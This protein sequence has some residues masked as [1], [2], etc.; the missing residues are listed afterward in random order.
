MI[1][2]LLTRL[3]FALLTLV[4]AS[5]AAFVLVHLSGSTPG[6]VALGA[7]GTPET[8]YAYDVSVGWYDPWHQQ[9]L[10]WIGT[11]ASGDL[12]RSLIDGRDIGAD[13]LKRLP[14]T[15][16]LAIGGTLLS[17]LIGV[18]LGVIAAVRGGIVDRM[19]TAV[20][21]FLL[22]LP[23]F[24][25]GIL[26]VLVFAVQLRVLPATGF[27]PFAKDPVRSLASLVLPVI[28]IAVTTAGFIARQSRA[29]M[30]EALAQEHIRTLRALGTPQRRIIGVHAL[31]SASLPIL[32]SIAIMFIQ[33]F[34]G[35][36]IIETLFAIPGIGQ[37]MQVAVGSADLPFVQALVLVATLVVVTI[38]LGLELLNRFLD[39]KLRSS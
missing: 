19:I 10:S 32:A 37:A 29:S 33:L 28:T 30:A 11:V 39:P 22:S 8:V 17:A 5:L 14:V 21:G 38:N 31:R 12:G 6:G 18:S 25:F 2:F 15:A 20:S 35:S 34:G 23:P 24:W 13:I 26:L 36:V 1:R 4:V 7:S 16:A 9:F 27:V 3:A